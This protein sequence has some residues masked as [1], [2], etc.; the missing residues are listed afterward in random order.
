MG[1]EKIEIERNQR[2]ARAHPLADRNA[3]AKAFAFERHGVDADVEQNFGAFGR[4]Q[5]DRV[6]SRVDGN[7]VSVARGD[8]LSVNRIDREPV[9]DHLLGKDGIWNSLQGPDL[10]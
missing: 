2:I 3:R 4:A 7:D 1:S 10:A 8:K 6:T 5:G 9:A